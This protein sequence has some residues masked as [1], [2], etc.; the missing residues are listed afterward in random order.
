MSG[1]VISQI[2]MG[3]IFYILLVIAITMREFGRA[4]AA[5]KLGCVLPRMEGRVSI[6]PLVHMD[7]MGTVI[8]PLICISLM[9]YTQF[10]LV[11][12]WGKP[13]NTPFTNPKTYVRDDVISTLAGPCMNLVVAFVSSILFVLFKAFNLNSYLF[14]VEC[15]I[16]INVVLF[17]IN[18]LPIPPL[19]GGRILRHVVKMSD[20]TY[21]SISR[22]GIFMFF[23]VIFLPPTKAIFFGIVQFIVGVFELIIALFLKIFGYY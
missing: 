8:F 16:L 14:V 5:D 2:K 23:A 1:D 13:V 7:L 21:L 18:M 3:G 15:S 9:V 17:V 4:Y 22:Y 19:D 20:S 12:G 10:P 11:F 6:N